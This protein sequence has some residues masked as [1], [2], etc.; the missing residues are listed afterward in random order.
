MTGIIIAIMVNLIFA[1]FMVISLIEMV[2]YLRAS[3]NWSRTTGT[4]VDFYINRGK[5]PIVSYITANG[6]ECKKRFGN[7]VYFH[8]KIGKKLTVLYNPENPEQAYLEGKSLQGKAVL[9]AV[10][11]LMCVLC[12]AMTYFIMNG[13]SW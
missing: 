8:W 11:L 12:I 7:A 9:F 13:G 10:T 5:D 3:K 2:K 4:L 6:K 1:G